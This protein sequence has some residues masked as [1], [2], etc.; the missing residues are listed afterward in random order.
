M[1]PEGLNPSQGSEELGH[2]PLGTNYG[3][4]VP[5]AE[6][7]LGVG[8][9]GAWGGGQRSNKGPTPGDSGN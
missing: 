5:H 7:V 6:A 1:G 3:A 2:M 8:K 9:W 4:W